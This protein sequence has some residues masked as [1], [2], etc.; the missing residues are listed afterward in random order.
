MQ[1]VFYTFHCVHRFDLLL[2]VGTLDLSLDHTQR[3]AAEA[4]V[5]CPLKLPAGAF[6]DKMQERSISAVCERNN[7][8]KLPI[9]L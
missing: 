2:R 1:K 7:Y 3:N 8:R 9:K 5:G 4:R 6:F